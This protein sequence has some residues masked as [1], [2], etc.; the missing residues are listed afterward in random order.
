MNHLF[1]QFIKDVVTLYR[2]TARFDMRYDDFN[3][4]CREAWKHDVYK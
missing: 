3:E 4:K 2:D 1:K